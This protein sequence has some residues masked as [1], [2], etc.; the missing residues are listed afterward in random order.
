MCKTVEQ[1]F[2][3]MRSTLASVLQAFGDEE[4]ESAQIIL[5]DVRDVL[6][7]MRERVRTGKRVT[8]ADWAAEQPRF[9]GCHVSVHVDRF[10]DADNVLLVGVPEICR[11]DDPYRV[12]RLCADDEPEPVTSIPPP[13]V[14]R[15][16]N[17]GDG[18][19]FYDW[20]K[21][22]HGGDR[23]AWMTR[24]EVELCWLDAREALQEE[25]QELTCQEQK[26]SHESDTQA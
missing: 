21:K 4:G 15:G 25:I 3:K 24:R 2:E 12:F 20:W 7:K 14:G 19:R 6:R 23:Q 1:E 18:M 26:D 8:A 13:H 17:R 22:R 16:R 11:C 9:E 10:G 5:A